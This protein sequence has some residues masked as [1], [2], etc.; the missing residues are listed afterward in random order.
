MT[1]DSLVMLSGEIMGAAPALGG[2]VKVIFTYVS[3][4]VATM[5]CIY[6]RTYVV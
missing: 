1:N 3:T 2:P 4:Y 5:M 6:I